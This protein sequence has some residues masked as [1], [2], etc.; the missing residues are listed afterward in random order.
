MFGNPVLKD[1][2]GSAEVRRGEPEYI[3]IIYVIKEM[4]TNTE[5]MTLSCNVK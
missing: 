3:Y 4:S 2:K 5:E 1:A